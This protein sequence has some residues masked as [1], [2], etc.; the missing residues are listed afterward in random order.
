MAEESLGPGAGRTLF[1][2]NAF[3]H[4][5]AVR[6]RKGRYF[7]TNLAQPLPLRRKAV[8]AARNSWRKVSRLRGCCG[9]PGQ[10]GC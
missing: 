8:L 7:L 10:P 2:R 4:N 3:P 1:T 9:N 6:R 5:C